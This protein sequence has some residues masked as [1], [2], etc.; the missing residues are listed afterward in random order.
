[1]DIGGFDPK[2]FMYYE[3][4]DLCRRIRQNGNE[5]AFLTSV[6]VTHNARRDSRKKLRFFLWHFKSVVRYL[7][8]VY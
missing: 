5:V 7:F 1:M 2:F 3:D 4:V 8:R 6:S